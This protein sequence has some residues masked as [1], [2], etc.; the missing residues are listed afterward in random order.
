MALRQAPDG[1]GG[2]TMSRI[3]TLLAAAVTAAATLVPGSTP[4]HAAGGFVFEGVSQED[5]FGCGTTYGRF[6]G[7]FTGVVSGHTY[8]SARLT[9]SYTHWQPPGG[10]CDVFSSIASGTMYVSDSTH[11]AGMTFNWT[12]E[13]YVVVLSIVGDLDGAAVASYA[14]TSPAAMPCGH[15]TTVQMSGVGSGT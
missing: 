11:A 7:T 10:L 6:T 1:I 5:C 4:A 13:N 12:R 8:T 9:M 14:I 15:P 3:T 2:F